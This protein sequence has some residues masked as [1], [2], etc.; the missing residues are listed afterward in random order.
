MKKS[1][2]AVSFA[3]LVY[4]FFSFSVSYARDMSKD[5]LGKDS[6]TAW[7]QRRGV[8]CIFAGR[9][10]KSW[11]RTCHDNSRACKYRERRPC[12]AQ[13]ICMDTDPNELTSVCTEWVPVRSVTCR[14][15][16]TGR[17]EMKWSRTCVQAYVPD[18]A[19]SRE[20]PDWD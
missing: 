19:C 1:L 7:E 11:F 12:D 3:I 15:Y 18:T 16:E 17:W 2:I 20:Y 13:N 9:D 14:D 5:P 4:V 8:S 6:C 10:S